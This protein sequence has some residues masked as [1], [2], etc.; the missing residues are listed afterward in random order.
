MNSAENSTE[1]VST[2]LQGL[3]EILD[4]LRI[5]DNVVW[6][7]DSIA[8]YRAFVTPFVRTSLQ[9]GKRIVYMRFGRHEPLV[10]PAPNVVTYKLDAL[11]G[12]ESFASRVHA[13]ITEEGRGA[14]YVF[15]CLS[16]LLSAWA[17]DLMIGNFFRVTC[18]Y[19]FDLDTVAYFGLL[20][21]SHSFKTTARI[22]ETTQVMIGI[23]KWRDAVHVHPIKVWQRHSPTMF[24]PHAQQGERFLPVTSSCD[25]TDLLSSISRRGTESSRRQLDYWDRLFLQAEDLL[26]TPG[27]AEAREQMIDQLCRLMI[28]REDRILSLARAYFSL[29]DLLQIKGRMIGTGFIGG[30]AVGMLL[31]RRILLSDSGFEWEKHLERHDS[32]FVGSDVYYSYIVHNGW[33]RLLMRQKTEDGYFEA[34]AELREKMRG[35]TFP[36]EIREVFQQ[37]LEYFGQYPIIVRSSSLLEDGFGNAF[38]GKY[39]SYFLANQ[40]AP[41]ERCARLEEAVRAIFASTMSEDALSYRRQR[42]LDRQEEQMGLL[43]MRVSGSYHNHYYFPELAGV[44]VSYNTFVWSRELNPEAGMLRLVLG[45]GTRAVDRVEGDY[46][47]IIALDSPLKRPHKGVEDTRRFSQRDVDLLNV[48]TNQ[49]E[50]VSLLDLTRQSIG[51]DWQRYAV[52]DREVA[53]KIADRGGKGQDVWLLTFDWLLSQTRFPETMQKM[54]KTVETAYRYPVDIEFT[55]NFDAAGTTILNLVQCR[56]LQTK[57]VQQ[58]IDMPE[59]IGD[60]RIFFA[61]EG[62]FMG[63]SIAQPIRRIIFVDPEEYTRLSLSDKY[64]V[65]RLVG[66]LNKRLG[67]RNEVPTLLMGP[68]RWGTS[69]PAL[70]VPVTFSELNNITA[71]AEIAFTGGNLMPEL[72]FGTHFFQDLVEADIFYV[73]IFPE[74]PGCSFNRAWFDSLP[75]ALEGLMPA[76]SR[77]KRVVKVC[78]LPDDG[79]QLMADV[80]SQKLLCFH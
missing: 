26:V 76:S 44:G 27:A 12:F 3:D 55:V 33:W 51:I 71:L 14:F 57:G 39:D 65:A 9:E 36:E 54:L 6:R 66:R 73:A 45:L 79:L 22:R 41:E 38:A 63:G 4:A 7:I 18:P 11:R 80:V 61:S 75:N 1:R 2:G 23:H 19:L 5:G 13:I 15:D 20:R 58:K 46:P 30:K 56:P 68:G 52:R 69:T 49:P 8:D 35:G 24:L 50:T 16:D 64:E 10:Q 28:G 29:E 21:G 74:S 59:N 32:F 48:E 62:H 77:Y 31:A 70:G 40:G 42:G 72:S 43:I 53:Q 67:D 25:A 60:E 78:N 17:T 47:C 37:M 34:A